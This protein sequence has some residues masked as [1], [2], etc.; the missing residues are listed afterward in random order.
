MR[1]LLIGLIHFYQ[2]AIS[3]HTAPACRFMPTCSAY[4]IEA[5]ERF[6][7]F[8]GTGLAIWR[9]LRCNP[10]GGHGYDPVPEK[11]PRKNKKKARPDPSEKDGPANGGHP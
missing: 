6:G 4:A 2:R 1:R 5:I 7:A 8:K 3:S 9:V 11:K 10:W